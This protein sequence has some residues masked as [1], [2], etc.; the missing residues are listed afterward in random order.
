MNWQSPAIEHLELL[1]QSALLNNV[2]ANNYGALNIFLYSKKF[3]SKIA[4]SDG[5]IFQKH[6]HDIHGK[7]ICFSFPQNGG[8][9][10]DNSG[11]SKINDALR[12]LQ[13]EAD[14]SG[15][16]GN[17]DNSGLFFSNITATEKDA[18]LSLWPDAECTRVDARGDYIYR[19]ENLASL[20]GKLYSKKRN[21]VNQFNKKYPDYVFEPLSEH[22]AGAVMEIESAWL[23][24]AEQNTPQFFIDGLRIEK[25]LIQCALENFS[26]LQKICSLSGGVLFVQNKPVAFCLASRLSKDVTDIHFE[27]CLSPFDKDGGF[28]VINQDFSK[29]LSTRFVNREEDLGIEGLRKAKRSYYPEA[30]LEKYDV[31]IL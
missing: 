8:G 6:S 25:D 23:L 24:K 26:V 28:A 13:K 16:S 31:R 12:A 11:N 9:N 29:T 19:T 20:P 1:Q 4:F 3:N 22:N 7:D 15:E 14:A 27:K 17:S 2:F 21:H 18:L 10:T 30:V 5:W